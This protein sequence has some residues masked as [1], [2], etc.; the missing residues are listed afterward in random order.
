[1]KKL[2][3]VVAALFLVTPSLC[4]DALVITQAMK[5]ATIAEIFIEE[6]GVRVEVEIGVADLPAFQNLL[7]DEI[8]A[9][10]GISAPPLE[11][12]LGTF[13][14]NDLKFVADGR[15]L[16]GRVLQ[17][18]ARRRVPR[19]EV[20]GEPLPVVPGVSMES[21]FGQVQVASFTR[22]PPT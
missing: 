20:T 14:R 21:L 13:F 2:S 4:P 11:E 3:L 12:R 1:M 17:M 15:V 18:K 6:G 5:A 22:D 10:M 7:P 19:D 16:P 9:R 8:L